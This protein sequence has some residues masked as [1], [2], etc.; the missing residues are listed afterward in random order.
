MA[1]RS[2]TDKAIRHIMGWAD[3]PEWMDERSALLDA[4][5]APACDRLGIGRE[6]LSQEIEEYDVGAMLFGI[7][8]EDLLS[9]RLPPDEKNIVDEYLER[10]G[11]RESVPGKTLS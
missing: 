5:L 3:R 8:F 7:M 6:E 2:D 4:H 9:R 1:K 11:W 10:R